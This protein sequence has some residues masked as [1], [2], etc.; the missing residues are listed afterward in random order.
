MSYGP[1]IW[2]HR[3]GLRFKG[4]HRCC[5]PKGHEGAHQCNMALTVNLRG[6]KCKVKS[7]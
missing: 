5:L 7:Q 4:I 2:T 3:C 1:K 6:P